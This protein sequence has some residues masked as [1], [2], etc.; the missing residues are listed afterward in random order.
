MEN[1]FFLDHFEIRSGNTKHT[2]GN[3]EDLTQDFDNCL[4]T[5]SK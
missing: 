2:F 1:P 4:I 3:N 5:A